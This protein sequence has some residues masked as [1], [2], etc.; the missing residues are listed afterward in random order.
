M[1]NLNH[2]QSRHIFVAS[3]LEDAVL[4]RAKE[5]TLVPSVRRREL[6]A[7]CQ[8]MLNEMRTLN[9]DH[10]EGSIFI[11]EAI[12]ELGRSLTELAELRGGNILEDMSV[13]EGRC[14]ACGTQLTTFVP[15]P[16]MHRSIYCSPC[17]EVIMPALSRLRSA[18]GFG[19]DFI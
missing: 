1:I 4:E 10:F 8:Q 9:A 5:M 17:L 15:V 16:S 3:K 19:T 18:E 14:A 12:D 7:E 13:G 2:P 6:Q 11:S